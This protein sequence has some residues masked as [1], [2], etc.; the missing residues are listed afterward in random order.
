M[1]KQNTTKKTDNK[2]A[3]ARYVDKFK[4]KKICVIGD[5]IADVYIFGKPYR[6]SREAPVVV[7]KYEEAKIYP[8]SAGNTINNLLALGAYVYPI[9]FIGKDST[10]NKLMDYFSQFRNVDT[11]GIIRYNG[12][13][14][15]KTRILAGDTHTSKQQVI[16][17]DRDDN[18]HYRQSE[19]V[20]L[21]DNLHK[22]SSR[23]DTFI[24]SDYGH[25]AVDK[26]VIEYVKTIAK[27]K[28]AVGDSRYNLKT[29]KGFTLITPNES[30]AYQLS[31]LGEDSSIEEVGKKI[32]HSMD[33]GALLITRGNT[34]MTLFLKD[35]T[36]HHIPISGKD[37]VTDVTGAGDTVCAVS[38][39]S[40][41]SGADFFT[42]SCIANYAAGV[43]VMKRGT[44]TI[45][46][47]ELKQAIE[48]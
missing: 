19:K 8:G 14:V 17:I 15:T 11:S 18:R 7:V 46:P 16:R 43:V 32:L 47:E 21:R 12:T 30:E 25:G 40:L 9:G 2:Q 20:Q 48:R 5:I 26:Y 39:L 33:L 6:L 27:N 38:A 31:G 24:V 3:F 36:M 22:I 10:G 1:K 42:A 4:G 13:T 44:A 45:G 28:T 34:G 35:G 41:A 29:F 23:A 37:D